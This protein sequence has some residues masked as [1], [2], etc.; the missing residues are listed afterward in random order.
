MGLGGLHIW[1]LL[2]LL[3]VVVLVFGTGKLKNI[4]A[5]LGN[6]IKGFRS[7]MGSPENDEDEAKRIEQDPAKRSAA[8]DPA[9]A[10]PTDQDKGK[11]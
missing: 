8:Q 3:V 10:K 2:I 6:A 1:H 5:D 4:G 11:V 9:Q 7:A